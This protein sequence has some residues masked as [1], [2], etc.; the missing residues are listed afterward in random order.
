RFI[1]GWS[2]EEKIRVLELQA[3]QLEGDMQNTAER[4][5]NL[6]SERKK[7][8]GRRDCCRDLLQYQEYDEMD[9]QLAA[10][11]IERLEEER[12]QIE[13]SSDILADLRDKLR[14]VEKDIEQTRKQWEAQIGIEAGLEKDRD[15]S[16]MELQQAQEELETAPAE[17]RNRIFPDLDRLSKETLGEKPVSLTNIKKTE[18]DL[19]EQI[20]RTIDNETEKV[21]RLTEKIVRQMSRYKDQFKAETI[22]VDASVEAIAEYRKMLATL[23][24]EDLPRHEDRFKKLLNEGTINSVA[25][26]QNQLEKEKQS[27]EQKIHTI[28]MSLREIEYNA[29]TYIQL[30]TER[31]Q[32]AEIRDFQQELRQCLSHTLAQNDFYNEGKFLQVKK[33]ID[34]FNGREG[35]VDMDQR[36]T[37]K[38]TD[39]R[40]WFTFAA[41]ERYDVDDSEKEFFSD[42]SGKSGGQKEKL[43]YTILASGL[44]YQF[45]LEWGEKRSRSFRF[46]VIDE[47]FGRGSDESTRYGLELFK[48]LNLQ[49]LIVTPLQKI[50]IIEDYIKSVFF[51][52]NQDG[53][54]SAVVNLT[55]QEYREEKH[56]YQSA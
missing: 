28:N 7:L 1:L 6:D 12:R 37:A 3:R 34:R 31:A 55:L 21:K 2:N 46:V 49:L 19:R 8:E 45:G 14:V 13:Q 15:Q 41:S 23:R 9:W 27:I 39:V 26:F 32:D 43:A 36:W 4:I 51:I 16:R 44:A 24:S 11:R 25:L 35:F 5:S 18:T 38:V 56:K 30:V 33:L 29:G 54:S 22:E 20:T 40:N 52:H 48:K 17:Q 50:H 53:K 10:R 42:S 47:A